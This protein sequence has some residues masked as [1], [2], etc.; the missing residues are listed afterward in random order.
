MNKQLSKNTVRCGLIQASNV[1]GPESSNQAIRQAAIDKHLKYIKQAADKKVK[2][3]CLQELFY[4]PYFAA[5]ENPRWYQLAERV[6]DGPTVSLMRQ[7]ARRY[8]MVI[9]APVY[10][11]VMSGEYYN[12]AAVIDADGKFLGKYRKNHLPHCHPGFWEKFYFRPGNLGYPV[13]QTQYATIGVYLCYDRHY[14]EGMRIMALKGA[15]IVFNPNATVS[16]L[17]EHIWKLEMPAHVAFNQIYAGVINR[18]G[19]E[20]PWLTG[21]FYGTSYFAD[22]RGQ[23]IAQA[24]RNKDEVLVADLDLDYIKEVRNNWQFYRDRRPETYGEIIK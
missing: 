6:P 11:E 13:F 8:K 15:Q 10:E 5:E 2:I 22:P 9:V 19:K 3:L 4:G 21:E 17:S 18:V 23:I 1:K 14:P 20:K 24:G 12:T 7:I 16:G